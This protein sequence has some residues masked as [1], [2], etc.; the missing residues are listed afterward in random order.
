MFVFHAKKY[1]EELQT[2]AP[3]MAKCCKQ[4]FEKNESDLDFLRIDCDSFTKCPSDSI[5]FA[6]MEKTKHAVVLPLDVWG[7]VG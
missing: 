4:A 1:L 6:V 2:Y 5:D 7:D 3:E